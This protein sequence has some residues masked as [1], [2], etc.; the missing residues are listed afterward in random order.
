MSRVGRVLEVGRDGKPRWVIDNLHYPVDA[1]VLGE[2]RVLITE[3]KGHRVTERDF[4]GNI[5][6]Q[7]DG[8]PHDVANAQ[9]LPNGNTFIAVQ[10]TGVLEVDRA[11]RVVVSHS[12]PGLCAGYRSPNGQITCLTEQSLCIRLDAEGKEIQR[13]PSGRGGGG[14]ACGIDVLANGNVLIAQPNKG[15]VVEADPHGRTV[16]RAKTPAI[17]T[18]TRLTNGHTL[19]ANFHS[20]SVVELDRAGKVVWEYKDEYHQ[21]RARRR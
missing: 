19:V 15:I 9:R 3:N 16:W 1:Y 12:V 11:G 13:F 14:W 6:W 7:H 18:A 21:F 8:L 2:N 4:Q 17:T 10:Y 5:L 20:Q